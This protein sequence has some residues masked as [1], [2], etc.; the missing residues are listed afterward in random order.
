MVSTGST[1]VLLGDLLP[2]I[3]LPLP[4]LTFAFSIGVDTSADV[5]EAADSS[6]DALIAQIV[7]WADEFLPGW[8]VDVLEAFF[9]ALAFWIP[10]PTMIAV[11]YVVSC[12]AA[13][14]LGHV[15]QAHCLCVPVSQLTTTPRCV[16]ATCQTRDLVWHGWW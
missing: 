4:G 2:K 11:E 5:T 14:R 6:D 3:P 12:T 15:V 9:K 16:A 7:D 8:A 10:H 13:C 1:D